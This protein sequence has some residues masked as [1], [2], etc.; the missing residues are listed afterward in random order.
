MPAD[1]PFDPAL[2]IDLHTHSWASDGTESP[3]EV[4]RQAARAGLGTLALTDH[5]T[6]AGWGEAA[7]EAR[8]LG[9]AFVP[10]IE[11]SSQLAYASVHVLGYLV[12]PDEPALRAETDAVR[13]SRVT[14]AERMVERIGA[15]YDLTW[16][17]VL[18]ATDEGAT[19]GRPHIADALVRKG[20]VADRD[21]AFRTVLHWRG[22]YY[23][24][25]HA[26]DPERVVRLIRGAGGVPV[27]AHPATRGRAVMA[28][29]RIAALVDAGLLGLEIGHREN[30]EQGRATLRHYARRYDLIVTGSSDYH[31]SGK[32]NRLGE[33]TT[34]PEMLD[35]IIAAG[36]GSDVVPATS[37]S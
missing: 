8:T 13:T 23:Q 17:D 6:A 26:P 11:F 32:P 14:R 19:V 9:L 25:H 7:A 21:E 15:D 24:P 20:I 30:D 4:V 16:R 31:G 35:R 1:R 3:A 22:G 34:S 28:G 36:T 27:L 33:H 2:P 5:D 29:E 10:G 37:T 12:D 18:D